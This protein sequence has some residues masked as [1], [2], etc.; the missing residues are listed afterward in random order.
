V[1]LLQSLDLFCADTLAD[2]SEQGVDQK[3]AAHADAAMNAPHGQLD[4]IRLERLAPGEDMLV[5]AVDERAV[6]VEQEGR[7]GHASS[8]PRTR[9]LP[10]AAGM[11]AARACS[12]V[13]TEM[14]LPTS[15]GVVRHAPPVALVIFGASGDLT[16][17]KPVPALFDLFAEREHLLSPHFAV[18]GFSRSTLS[19]DD[20]RALLREGVERFSRHT[21]ISEQAWRDFSSALHYQRGQVDDPES[22]RAKPATGASATP[23]MAGS[24]RRR[25]CTE[26]SIDGTCARLGA[27]FRHG[28]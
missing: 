4:A 25:P 19:D 21:P 14:A 16:Q 15:N 13:A 22:Y 23:D 5:H 27:A 28:S 10:G 2:F 7:R 12:T 3:A 26:Q 11:R 17:R 9:A 8:A 18:L 24:R 20:F 6:Q 1:T